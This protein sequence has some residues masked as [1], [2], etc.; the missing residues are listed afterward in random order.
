M[1]RENGEEGEIGEE[2]ITERAK[3]QLH[4]YVNCILSCYR[5]STHCVILCLLSMWTALK[6]MPTLRTWFDD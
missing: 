4:D 6:L 5:N 3:L 2:A 1:L